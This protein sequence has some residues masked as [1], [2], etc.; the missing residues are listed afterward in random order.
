[1]MPAS[2]TT[3][4]VSAGKEPPDGEPENVEPK[5]VEPKDVEPKN[6]EFEDC[7]LGDCCARAPTSINNEAASAAKSNKAFRCKRPYLRAYIDAVMAP[8]QPLSIIE[9][10]L[11]C[12]L[13]CRICSETCHRLGIPEPDNFPQPRRQSFQTRIINPY[14]LNIIAPRHSNP[15]FRA[16]KL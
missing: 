10:D 9:I 2:S 7:R 4:P 3:R 1:M 15:V 14:C 12:A 16:F 6:G 11:W 5:N 13:T 8:S